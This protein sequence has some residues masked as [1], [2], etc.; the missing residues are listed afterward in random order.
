MMAVAECVN[1]THIT[2]NTNTSEVLSEP[3]PCTPGVTKCQYRT[4]DMELQFD[5]T[6]ECSLKNDDEGYCPL[7]TMNLMQQYIKAMKKVWWQDNCHT[8]DRDNFIA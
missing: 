2:L 3:Y 7:P 4:P 8:Y 6:C 1:I 5:L